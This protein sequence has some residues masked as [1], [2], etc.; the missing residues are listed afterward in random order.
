MK[1]CTRTIIYVSKSSGVFLPTKY[2][3]VD[4]NEFEKA[5]WEKILA[6]RNNNTNEI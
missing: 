6:Q 2:R 3:P 1:M 5:L 4:R